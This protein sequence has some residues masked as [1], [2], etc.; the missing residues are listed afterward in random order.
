VISTARVGYEAGLVLDISDLWAANNWE[1]QFGSL[2]A[3]G[4]WK[5]KYWNIPWNIDSFPGFW[6]LSDDWK[7]RG[8]TAPKSI[9][10]LEKLFAAYK[11]AGVAPLLVAN[12]EKWHM[13][14]LVEYTILGVGGHS[15]WVGLT[16]GSTKWTDPKV[17]AAFSRI[18]DWLTKGYFYPNMN[19]YKI[20]EVF[21]FWLSG[22]AAL[23]PGG[24]WLIG[25]ADKAG[26]ETQYFQQPKLSPDIENAVV[27]STEPFSIPAHAEHPED[28]KILLTYMASAEAQQIF[29]NIALNPMSNVGVDHSKLP[30]PVQQN[31]TDV[32]TGPVVLGF[33]WDLPEPIFTAAWAG[34]QQF[35]DSPT[36]DVIAKVLGDVDTVA[37]RYFTPS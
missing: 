23:I 28:A 34:I 13:P 25:V 17:H 19:A 29:A 14:Y 9:D 1:Q 16:T 31:V 12:I 15:T 3:N 27:A 11:S 20:E 18:A 32:R 37:T 10:E 35:A 7:T 4:K 21:P 2:S 6:Y 26:K 33:D 30:G 8:F 24:S 36:E 22:Q 5:G